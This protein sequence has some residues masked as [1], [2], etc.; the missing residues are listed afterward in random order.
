MHAWLSGVCRQAG[1]MSFIRPTKRRLKQLSADFSPQ[2]FIGLYRALTNAAQDGLLTDGFFWIPS[3]GGPV[4]L[5]A[6]GQGTGLD[7]L[8]P[9][10]DGAP[11][12]GAFDYTAFSEGERASAAPLQTL[13]CL[14]TRAAAEPCRGTPKQSGSS[15]SLALFFAGWSTT[16]AYLV[17]PVLLIISQY[18]S[19]K[20]MQPA[21][22]SDDPS[23]AQAQ[24]ILKILPVMIGWF[25]LNVPSGAG[26]KAQSSASLVRR[27]ALLCFLLHFAH[28]TNAP[29]RLAP[30]LIARV[31]SSAVSVLTAAVDH[32]S[33]CFG[34]PEHTLFAAFSSSLPLF[35]RADVV[36]V[37]K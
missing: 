8:F 9:L 12:F 20:I 1:G 35:C 3:L 23:Q 15:N 10:I 34:T 27:P 30:L 22:A 16:A 11:K 7:W 13:L 32:P 31:R 25:A 26:W 37:H 4:A 5:G 21:T 2:V 18:A 28:S 29:P 36:L 17:L 24:T 14:S 6:D 33:L 19:Q